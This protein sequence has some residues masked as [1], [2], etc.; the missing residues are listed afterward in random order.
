MEKREFEE[1]NKNQQKQN[2][3]RNENNLLILEKNIKNGQNDDFNNVRTVKRVIK[4]NIINENTNNLTDQEALDKINQKEMESK[5]Q[6][7]NEILKLREQ[8]KD[9]QNDLFHQIQY[10]KQETQN[11]NQQRFEALKEIEKLKDDLSKQK[12]DENLR[13]KYV[14]EAIVNDSK[15]TNNLVEETHLPGVKIP[16]IILPVHS[17]KE[18]YYEEKIRHPNRIIPLPKLN[19][20]NEKAV[21]TDSK[22]VDIET[23]DIVGG[24]ELYQPNNKLIDSQ[25]EDYKINNRGI[26][27]DGDYG[28]LRNYHNN[29]LK[30]SDI[31]EPKT[32]AINKNIVNISINN[33]NIK[34]FKNIKNIE[35]NKDER[36]EN[37]N[38][39]LQTEEDEEF[40]VNNIYNKNLERLRFLNDMEN[41]FFTAKN[42]GKDLISN[43][44]I[45][46]DNNDDFIKK[47]NKPI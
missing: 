6:L 16:E 31:L 46:K 34:S 14:Y 7:N 4:T 28:T 12:A 22:F 39:N 26:D 13:N 3:V 11:A 24:L 36:T 37:I 33:K 47:L 18:L 17:E 35:K 40:E 5:M 41:N 42:K 45:E 32:N 23:K 20:L 27:I 38:I 15:A 2:K 21:K 9:Q 25:D 8:M 29:V 43:N 1:N 30:N 10:L 19:E 44:I